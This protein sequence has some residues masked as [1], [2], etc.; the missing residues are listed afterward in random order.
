[1]QISELS[2]EVFELPASINLDS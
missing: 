1:M 2:H